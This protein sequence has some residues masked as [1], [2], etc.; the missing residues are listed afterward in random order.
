MSTIRNLVLILPDQ[1]DPSLSAFDGFDGACDRVLICEPH[2]EV[3]HRKEA[4]QR[5]AFSLACMRH[6]V[7]GLPLPAA[8]ILSLRSDE[9]AIAGG[10]ILAVLD[11]NLAELRPERV[12]TVEPGSYESRESIRR[13]CHLRKVPI[14]FRADRHFMCETEAFHLCAGEERDRCMERFLTAMRGRYGILPEHER[15]AMHESSQ[16]GHITSEH[17]P[18]KA[19]AC[20]YDGN[21]ATVCAGS[22]GG[23]DAVEE[24]RVVGLH[25]ASDHLKD[26]PFE[27]QP[28]AITEAA[29]ADVNR[30]F[31]DHPGNLES[32]KWPTS[33]EQ[34]LEALDHFVIHQLAATTEGLE[35][36]R[37]KFASLRSRLSALL[38][39]KLLS[40]A[41]VV[42]AAEHALNVRHAEFRS[43]EKLVRQVL[44]W[45]EYV[46]GFY[47]AEMPGY[48]ARNFFNAHGTLPAFYETGETPMQCLREAIGDV[49]DTGHAP[50][51]VRL[52]IL[53]G[54][55][56]YL[57]TRPTAVH[58]WFHRMFAD[59][60]DWIEAPNVFGLSQWSD[61]G[62]FAKE[63][64][65]PDGDSIGRCSSS[66]SRCTFNPKLTTGPRACPFNALKIDFLARHEGRLETVESARKHLPLL[67]RIEASELADS[68][69]RATTIREHPDNLEPAPPADAGIPSSH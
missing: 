56:M 20:G 9:T 3:V 15:H 57:G 60:A 41:E 19:S 10:T 26:N 5:V 1:L 8:S 63:L 33:R 67:R 69:A 55:A 25:A 42:R 66:C 28:D 11:R 39:V 35:S 45:R 2:G 47:W 54:F 4:K 13:V 68:C 29:I 22:P 38:N 21:G 62:H 12:V 7:D 27:A 6:F 50:P 37:F 64:T 44:G 17:E 48:T 43:V 24:M 40:P 36:D 23:T 30:L 61:G 52:H 53:G 34:A 58:D 14:D 32:F 18:P 31:P 16:N 65:L 59:A 51:E 46:R 49:L